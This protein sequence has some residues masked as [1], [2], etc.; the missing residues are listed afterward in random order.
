MVRNTISLPPCYGRA[1][2]SFAVWDELFPGGCSTGRRLIPSGLILNPELTDPPAGLADAA[3]FRTTQ[4]SLVIRAVDASDASSHQAL[5]RLCQGYWPAVHAFIARRG[6]SPEDAK[7]LT[8]GFF[9][10]LLEKDWLRA[11]DATKGRFRTFLLT[12]VTRFLANERERAEALKR[13]GGQTFLSLDAENL[14]G[15]WTPELADRDT[16]EAA[17]ERRWAETLLGRVM[18][19]LQAEFDGGGRA[20]RFEA[21]KCFLTDDRGETSY[22]A[23]AERLG[24]S[25]SAVRSGIHRLRQRYG[26]LVRAEIAETMDSPADVEGEIRHLVQVLGS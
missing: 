26:E 2:E 22:A 25:E 14:H 4:W 16:P 13:G 20:G 12:A 9:A 21:L 17:F 10:R 24:M 19:R 11:A 8:Q 5:E 18:Q 23:V 1:A 15:D 3:R 7:D 6:H